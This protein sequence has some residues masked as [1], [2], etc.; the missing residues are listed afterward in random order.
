M[1]NNH[2]ECSNDVTLKNLKCLIQI[3][4]G[5]TY[6]CRKSNEETCIAVV[7]LAFSN[8]LEQQFSVAIHVLQKS[9]HALKVLLTCV[10]IRCSTPATGKRVIIFIMTFAYFS[11]KTRVTQSRFHCIN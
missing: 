11:L 1:T 10:T 6:L 5:S 8:F 2:E 7:S 9:V 4:W 3:Y